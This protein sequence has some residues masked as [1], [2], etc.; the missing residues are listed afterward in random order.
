MQECYRER[1]EKASQ[2]DPCTS[3]VWSPWARRG[4]YPVAGCESGVLTDDGRRGGHVLWHGGSGWDDSAS[5]SNEAGR[6]DVVSM[7]P[8][9]GSDGML[10]VAMVATM[11][12]APSAHWL[13]LQHVG[14]W[15]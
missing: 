12:K 2:S 13:T 4:P 15:K 3:P 10:I 8:I 1:G 9:Y 7:P 6:E 5:S 11:K 14:T